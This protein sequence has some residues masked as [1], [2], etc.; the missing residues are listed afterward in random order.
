MT[1]PC[2]VSRGA[3]E[4]AVSETSGDCDKLIGGG[5]CAPCFAEGGTEVSA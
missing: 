2:L 5:H 1:E 3:L 4:A